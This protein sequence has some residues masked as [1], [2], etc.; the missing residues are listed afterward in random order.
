MDS[1][2]I[3]WKTVWAEQSK[4]RN[5]KSKTFHLTKGFWLKILFI[6]HH[7]TAGEASLRQKCF[8]G[9]EISIFLWLTAPSNS[10]THFCVSTGNISGTQTS[11]PTDW[12]RQTK[13]K[14]KKKTQYRVSNKAILARHLFVSSRHLRYPS[15]PEKPSF[16]K[17]FLMAH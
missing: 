10:F 2:N 8:Q 1:Q 13:N 17:A 9:L 4:S 7:P 5:V 6:K 16:H 3:L 11:L 12:L 14:P 15:K